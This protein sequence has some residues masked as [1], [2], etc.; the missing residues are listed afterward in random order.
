M[1]L[2]PG[3]RLDLEPALRHVYIL[4]A[5]YWVTPGSQLRPPPWPYP[6]A[7]LAPIPEMTLLCRRL[8][9]CQLLPGLKISNVCPQAAWH[10]HLPPGSGK[11]NCRWQQHYRQLEGALQISHASVSTAPHPLLSEEQLAIKYGSDIQEE[12]EKNNSSSDWGI[13]TLYVTS[14]LFPNGVRHISW[15]VQARR[16]AIFSLYDMGPL[17]TKFTPLIFSFS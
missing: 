9:I 15:V 16:S 7:W 1:P 14:R 13:Y 10:C 2:P 3:Q 11:I 5:R 4:L 6:A 12:T 8:I 17:F